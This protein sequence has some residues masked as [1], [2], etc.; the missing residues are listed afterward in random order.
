MM[1][2]HDRMLTMLMKNIYS[3]EKKMQ[4]IFAE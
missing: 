3:F 4:N 2:Y 1:C